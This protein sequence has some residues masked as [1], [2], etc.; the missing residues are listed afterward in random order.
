MPSRLAIETEIRSIARR[1]GVK[2]VIQRVRGWLRRGDSYEDAFREALREAIGEGDTV[3]D[4][5]ANLGVYTR[6]FSDWVGAHGTI[7][8][9]EPTPICFE[10]LRRGVRTREN[11]S[12]FQI[13]LGASVATMPMSLAEDRKG[14]THSLVTAET[15]H[16]DVIEV[17]VIPGDVL[18]ERE[19]L[20]VP[21]V[22]KVD[23]E[24]FELEV[25]QGLDSTLRDERCRAVFCEVHFG[26]LAARGEK[27]APRTIERYLQDRGFHTRWIDSSHLGAH[28]SSIRESTPTQP[29]RRRS[30]SSRR[31][32]H[33]PR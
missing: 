16:R 23:V 17:D 11:L 20:A 32:A 15:D 21:R 25:L 9:I 18:R 2:P 1:V 14:A 12:F 33:R 4:V 30:R 28:R 8:A 6:L 13:A 26:L 5:G 24:G 22:V 29:A 3:W 27:Q 7:V 19:A 10:A 31:Q